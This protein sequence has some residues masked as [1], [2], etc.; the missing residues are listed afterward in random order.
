MKRTFTGINIQWPIS[1]LILEGKK[2]IETRTYPLPKR[3]VNQELLMIETPGPKGKFKARSV[4]I[5]KFTG[6]IEYRDS[7]DFY[8]DIDRHCVQPGSLW[9]WKDE[10][11]K[12]GWVVEV[13]EILPEP[14]TCKKRGIVYR[15]N[16]H[17]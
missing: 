7:A 16:I 1:Q 15:K 8:M 17:I 11:P 13:L 5:I 6:C 12:Y 14:I 4:A 9:E 2:S 10:K 3:L